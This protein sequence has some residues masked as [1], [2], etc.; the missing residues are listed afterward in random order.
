MEY[1]E[2]GATGIEISR[3]ALGCWA[4]GGDRFWGPQDDK[5]S[6]DT[7]SAALDCG[8]NFIDTAEVY[9]AGGRAEIVLGKALAGRRE[10]AIIATKVFGR[11]LAAGKVATA[12]EE[13]LSRLGTDYVDL[14]YI[15]W[16]NP[17]IPLEETAGEM[18][19]L[20]ETGKVRCLGISNFGPFFLNAL[21]ATGKIGL[22]AVNQLPYNLLWRAIEYEVLPRTVDKGMGIVAYSS[23]AQGLLTGMYSA[24]EEV[25]D[26]LKVTRFYDAKH[27][28]AEHGELGCEAEVFA[29]ISAL[30]TVAEREGTRLPE[31][32]LSWVLAKEEVTSVLSG[33]RTPQ[34]IIQ[35]ARTVETT[36][37]AQVVEEIA[38][39]TEDVKAKIGT[40]PD[41][42]VGG[43][44]SRYM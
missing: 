27:V 20:V 32:A 40:N 23:L 22:F 34:E 42:W 36:V 10:Q 9:G 16:P 33:A 28:D 43:D 12:C 4:F 6:I 44:Q 3:L 13:S 8:I 39:L 37:T 17:D 19:R 14:Y 5:E 1:T 38:S 11:N 31:L 26:Y 35:N 41:M 18:E 25:P 24:V 21:N 29:A 15:H 30:K 7:V 2:L